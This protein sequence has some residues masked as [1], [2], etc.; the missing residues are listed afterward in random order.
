[1]RLNRGTIALILISLVIIAGMVLLNN[2]RAAAPTASASPTP[3]AGPIFPEIADVTGQDKIVRFEVVNITDSSKVVMTKDSSGVWTVAEATNTQELATDQTKAVGTMSVL[4]SL[5]AAD[6]FETDKLA[7]FGL[8]APK[9][10]MKLTDS[11]GKVYRLQIGNAAVANPRYYGLVNEDTKTV[12]V[13]P[14]DLVDGLIRQIAQPAYVPSPTPTAT[15]TATAN[16]YSEVEQTATSA[17]ELQQIF[18]TMTSAAQ[19]TAAATT[20]APTAEAT[21]EATA[22]PPTAAPSNTP[23]PTNTP[24]PPSATPRPTTAPAAE[25]TAE[26]TPESTPAS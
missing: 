23:A 21:A 5:A 22:V 13:L 17:A 1:M 15:F 16:P 7:D 2:Q 20:G 6:K 3:S 4:A 26:A 12:Y 25:A 24:V 11:D 10:D 8:D 9:Y 14:K 18:A 19:Q